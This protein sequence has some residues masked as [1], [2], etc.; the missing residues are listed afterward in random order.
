ML[1][2]NFTQIN[3]HVAINYAEAFKLKNPSIF[4]HSS[5]TGS[6]GQHSSRRPHP[7]APLGALF[8]GQLRDSENTQRTS[9]RKQLN[10]KHKHKTEVHGFIEV[11]TNAKNTNIDLFLCSEAR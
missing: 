2:Y 5:G 7:L 8:R 10:K 11:L 4:F 1:L 6:Q 9:F 3:L